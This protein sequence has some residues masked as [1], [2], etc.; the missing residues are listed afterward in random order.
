MRLTVITLALALSACSMTPEFVRPDAPVPSR[1]PDHASQ[2]DMPSAALVGWRSMFGDPRLQALIETALH[3][4]RDLRIAMLNVEA[5]RAQYRIQRSEQFPA[6]GA[7]AGMTRERSR[8]L[9]PDPTVQRQVSAGLGVTAFELDLWGRAR[10][11]SEAA[12]SRYLASEEARR[13]AK[14]S[15]VASVADAYFAERLAAEQEALA[16]RTLANWKEQRDLALQLRKALQNSGIDV[17]QAEG[18]V[19]R[20]EAEVE[21]RHRDVLRA[22]NALVQLV[23][24]DL[25]TVDLPEAISLERQPVR[26]QLPAGL[27][28]DLLIHRPDIR[29]AEQVL[30]AANADIGAARAAFFPRVSLTTTLGFASPDFG[31]LFRGDNRVW[32]FAPSI[33]Q[34]LFDAGRLRA[35]LRL[36]ELRKSVAVAQ[37]E[38]AIQV[39]F[40]EV[41]DGLAGSE[42]YALQSGAQERVV[43]EEQRRAELAGQRYRA[44]VDGRL[45]WL[46]A[47]RELFAAQLEL[48]A[49]RR[50]ALGNATGLYKALGGGAFH[51]DDT[52]S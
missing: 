34:P 27:P 23:A 43:A 41:A 14:V 8:S 2:A 29:Q 50:D 45:E 4:N 1:Y 46:D 32:S 30:R 10:S 3:N 20:A 12:F 6:I 24:A 15:L 31:G 22:R 13:A 19:A 47:Q 28:S 9:S 18:Q 42:T 25:D 48:L 16:R 33:T 5:T 11:M 7:T 39:A 51:T 44:G 17:A 52:G 38:Q 40:R 49:L 21:A 35:E 37:Y 26:T 36:S